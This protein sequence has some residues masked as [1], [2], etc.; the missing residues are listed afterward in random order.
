MSEIYDKFDASKWCKRRNSHGDTTCGALWMGLLC[1]TTSMAINLWNT[2]LHHFF[3]KL[4]IE[5]YT[6]Q[7]WLSWWNN[8]IAKKL[9]WQDWILAKCDQWRPFFL[10][11]CIPA[12]FPQ[13]TICKST[14]IANSHDFSDLLKLNNRVYETGLW[15]PRTKTTH[16]N[17]GPIFFCT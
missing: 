14:L 1:H 11:C 6:F 8:E 15:Y 17:E 2:Y 5:V 16:R 13:Q 7:F 10:N 4:S 12:V 9:E 3:R